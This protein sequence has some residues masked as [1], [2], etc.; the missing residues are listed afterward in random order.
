ME[1]TSFD[2]ACPVEEYDSI[3]LIDGKYAWTP[4]VPKL[5]CSRVW[6]SSTCSEE[7]NLFGGMAEEDVLHSLCSDASTVKVQ[8]WT[9]QGVP[10]R[11]VRYPWGDVPYEW[12]AGYDNSIMFQTEVDCTVDSHIHISVEPGD[13]PTY[14]QAMKGPER[15][16]WVDA[17][18]NEMNALA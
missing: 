7:Q 8:R 12:A 17:R 3:K 16:Q 13:D 2:P 18:E 5:I 9:S 15:Q 11:T 1:D 6:S 10:S 4:N 14:A